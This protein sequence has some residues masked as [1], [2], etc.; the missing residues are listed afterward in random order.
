MPTASKRP[1]TYVD[2]IVRRAR[3]RLRDEMRARH[4]TQTQVAERLSCSQTQIARWLAGRRSISFLDMLRFADAVG[5]SFMEI[6]R[7]PKREFVADLT[8]AEVRLLSRLNRRPE[9]LQ[10]VM[11]LLDLS[12]PP[13]P[14][15]PA[16]RPLSGQ[17]PR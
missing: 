17:P 14:K 2:D 16:G 5:L 7:D 8:P 10:A 13:K 6:V 1:I 4:L 15:G 11:A 12:D 9:M 3:L